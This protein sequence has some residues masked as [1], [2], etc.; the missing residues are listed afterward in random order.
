V[1]G[2]TLLVAVFVFAVWTKPSDQVSVNGSPTPLMVAVSVAGPPAQVVPPPVTLTERGASGV[3][4]ALPL[5][6]P[7]QPFAFVMAVTV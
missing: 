4:V 7:L 5:D 2:E 3:T 1:F 6:A